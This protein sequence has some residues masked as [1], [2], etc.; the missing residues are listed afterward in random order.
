MANRTDYEVGCR[1]IQKRV[2]SKDGYFFMSDEGIASC[3]RLINT[4]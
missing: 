2:N 4:W 3:Q 1:D